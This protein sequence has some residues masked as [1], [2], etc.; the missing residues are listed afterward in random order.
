MLQIGHRESHDVDIFLPD[1]QLLGFLD[2][3]THDFDLVEAPSGCEGDGA[4]FLKLSYESIGEI[5]FI[6]GG[7]LTKTPT[8][9]CSIEGVRTRLETV[10]EIVAKK[11]YHRAA[12][13]R[14]RDIFDIAAAAIE[15]EQEMVSALKDYPH[16]VSQALETL[17]RLNPD[18][19]AAAISQLQIKNEYLDVAK[20]ALKRTREVLRA[21]IV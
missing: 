18:F 7:A 11:V 2:P 16:A 1:P 3:S 20:A 13:L 17:E 12:S 10:A 5:D 4:R 19:V 21:A 9:I 14:P 8:T 6:V 15:H